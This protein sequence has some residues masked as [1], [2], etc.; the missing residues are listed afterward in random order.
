MKINDNA[1]AWIAPLIAS[2]GFAIIM[3]WSD[4]QA[5]KASLDTKVGLVE[6]EVM[7]GEQNKATALNTQAVEN[8]TGVVS[9]LSDIIEE[10]YG[11]KG[12]P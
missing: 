5:I 2:V 9:K 8:L 3:M 1:M 10:A 4:I 11:K 7:K 12:N 6:F